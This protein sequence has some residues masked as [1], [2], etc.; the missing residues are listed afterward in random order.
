VSRA[1]MHDAPTEIAPDAAFDAAPVPARRP[2]SGRRSRAAVAAALAGTVV[3]LFFTKVLLGTFVVS[4][5]DFLAALGGQTV[6][7]VSFIVME[8]RLPAAVVG[9][10]AGAALGL[11]GALFQTLLR[12]PLAS[13]DVI[14]IGYGAAAAAVAG[15]LL[16]GLQGPALG[17]VAFGGGLAVALAIYALADSGRHTGG[18][19]ILVGIGFAA[20]LQAV[21]SYLLT[22]T[23]VRTAADALHWMV[24]SLSSSTWERAGVLAA[25]LLVL[26]PLGALAAGRLNILELGDDAAAGLGL[27]VRATRLGLVVLGVALSAAAIAVTGPLAFVAFLSGPLARMLCGGRPNLACSALAG[28]ALVLAAE[29][30]G[31]N[32]FGATSVPVG[33]V[34]GALGAPFLL[35]LLVRSNSRGT[36]G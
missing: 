7:G 25:V 8:D 33:V 10:L 12:N 14:G 35:W 27:N 11:S 16:F 17:A 2:R 32:A 6:P 4:V 1:G 26:F 30:V 15:M 19:L 31:S 34:T 5:P 22:R 13:P 24:G 29:F 9:T 21:I 28:A 18:R 36:G 23:D 20:M 3:V